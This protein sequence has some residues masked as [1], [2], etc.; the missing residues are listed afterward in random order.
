MIDRYT[1]QPYFSYHDKTICYPSSHVMFFPN[2]QYHHQK[3]VDTHATKIYVGVLRPQNNVL[4][5]IIQS[6]I[7]LCQQ[8]IVDD[9]MILIEQLSCVTFLFDEN[10]ISW[11]LV[12]C[13]MSR[14]PNW[15]K[16]ELGTKQKILI[17][18]YKEATFFSGKMAFL[19]NFIPMDIILLSMC[20]HYSKF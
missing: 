9:T 20:I 16:I 8:I 14:F 3:K 18:N 11:Y 2:W 12:N 19:L 4:L 15:A 1:S 7:R 17:S 10:L 5:Y 6:K 13:I